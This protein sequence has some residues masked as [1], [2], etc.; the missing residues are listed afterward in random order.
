MAET[1]HD[2]RGVLVGGRHRQHPFDQPDRSLVEETVRPAAIVALDDPADRRRRVDADRG[3]FERHGVD[4]ADV[5]ARACQHDR[6]V[7]CGPIE[8]L[9][10]G[11]PPFSHG[12]LVVSATLQPRA[13][14]QPPRRLFDGMDQFCH[15]RDPAQIEQRREQL[16]D[17]P[18]VGVRVVEPGNDAAA[19]EIDAPRG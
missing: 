15:A 11:R 13:C 2:H 8:I 5:A 9:A 4:G 3:A 17:F 14:R 12:C 16:P 1:G 7:R 18:D 6:N 10:G 19:A